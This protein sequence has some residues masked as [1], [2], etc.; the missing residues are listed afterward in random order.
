[1]NSAVL[2]ASCVRWARSTFLVSGSPDDPE[3]HH[4]LGVDAGWA[5]LGHRGLKVQPW[6]QHLPAAR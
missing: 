4:L 5:A 3:L 2:I 6:C 1:Q